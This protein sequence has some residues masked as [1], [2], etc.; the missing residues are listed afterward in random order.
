MPAICSSIHGVLAMWAKASS[1]SAGLYPLTLPLL[2][3][4]TVGF[5]LCLKLASPS[6]IHI[7]VGLSILSLTSFAITGK[8]ARG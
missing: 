5:S 4:V 6:S 1:S 8:T 7:S 2:P 3:L